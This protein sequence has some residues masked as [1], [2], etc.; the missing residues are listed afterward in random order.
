MAEAAQPS[1]PHNGLAM[2]ARGASLAVHL[3]RGASFEGWATG[4][5]QK[6]VDVA[7]ETPNAVAR[8]QPAGIDFSIS[9]TQY[10]APWP[11][12]LSLNV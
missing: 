2:I 1:Y 10:D 4:R 3:H 5:T 8:R 6:L 12:I 7:A 9:R 11:R